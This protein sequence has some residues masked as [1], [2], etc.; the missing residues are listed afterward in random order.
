MTGE[1][2]LE[3]LCEE[4]P[5]NALPSIREQL[6]KAFANELTEAGYQGFT[7]RAVSTVRR[8]VVNAAGLPAL[9]PDR[10]E[11]VFGPP[12]RAAFW[13]RLADAGGT[14]FREGQGVS[15]QPA[16]G[17]ARASSL[18]TPGRCPA[19]RPPRCSARSAN[20]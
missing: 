18:Q 5:A 10:E 13:R 14:R 1:F 3:I 6:A 7:V 8:I 15:G 4:I 11:E 9:Q 12:V 19:G 20:G 17:G 16:R 2:L